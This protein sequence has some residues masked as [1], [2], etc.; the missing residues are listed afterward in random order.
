MPSRTQDLRIGREALRRLVAENYPVIARSL[1]RPL[2]HLLSTSREACSGDIDKFMIMVVVAIRTTEH[3]SFASF[4]PAQLM[5]GDL[6]VFPTLGTNVRSIADSTGTPKETVRRKV[7]ELIE[8]GWISRQ[9]NELR[10][11]A[12]AYRDLDGA[13]V[14]IEDLAI[15]NF[16][17]VADLARRRLA[18]SPDH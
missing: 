10:F 16:Q 2:L 9:A 13:R 15:S 4:T 5:S 17:V 7:G 14:A 3:E 8:A 18:S 6:P 11:T 1:L 12:L